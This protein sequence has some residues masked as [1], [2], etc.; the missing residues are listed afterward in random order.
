MAATGLEKRILENNIYGFFGLS[1]VVLY[2]EE[3]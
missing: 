2:K 1:S 3:V